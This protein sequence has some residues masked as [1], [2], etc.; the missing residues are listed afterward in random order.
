MTISLDSEARTVVDR[1]APLMGFACLAW[2][3]CGEADRSMIVAKLGT[4]AI[5]SRGRAW[6]TSRA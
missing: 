4:D 1:T 2:T 3:Y 6:A 5:K